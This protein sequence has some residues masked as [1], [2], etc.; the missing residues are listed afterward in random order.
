MDIKNKINNYIVDRE[1]R[2][3]YYNNMLDIINY[4][5]IIDFSSSCIKIKYNKGKCFINGFNLCIVKMLDDEVLI[6]GRI[7]SIMLS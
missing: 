4:I 2:I 5:E 3:I 7:D 1:F 6:E